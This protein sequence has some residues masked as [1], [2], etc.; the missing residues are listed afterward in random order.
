MLATF[1]EL[2]RYRELLAEFVRRDLKV[3]YRGSILGVFWSLVTPLLSVAVMTY[4][5]GQVIGLNQRNMSAYILAAYLPFTFFN[6]ALMDSSQSV[7]GNLHIMKKVYVPHELFPIAVVI[8]NAIHLLIALGVLLA[9]MFLVY[10]L[11]GFQTSPFTWHILFLPVVFAVNIMLISGLSLIISALNVFY[12]DVKHML[13]ILLWILFFMS[14]V[15]YFD[16]QVYWR[17]KASTHGM[18][19]Y[20]LYNLNPVAVLC[21][22]YRKCLV[23]ADMIPINNAQHAL[24]H[25]LPF[26]WWHFGYVVVMAVVLLIFGFWNFERLKW[27]FVERP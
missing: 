24:V 3:R 12:E 17:A 1:R 11:S 14:P 26:N 15:M 9:Y 25:T 6:T 5:V 16:E 20:D 22:M 4:V 2:Y 21:T 8:S 13:G 27:R 10:A 7:L 23:A 19:M 18:L